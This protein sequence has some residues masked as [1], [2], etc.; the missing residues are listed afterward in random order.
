MPGYREVTEDGIVERNPLFRNFAADGTVTGYGVSHPGQL[1]EKLHAHRNGH[2][3]SAAAASLGNL[4]ELGFWATVVCEAAEESLRQGQ[5]THRGAV[6]GVTMDIA[7]LLDDRLGTAASQRC[8][9]PAQET[10]DHSG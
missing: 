1:Y 10:L 8:W 3:S 5:R 2:L 4:V 9:G 7:S 6:H